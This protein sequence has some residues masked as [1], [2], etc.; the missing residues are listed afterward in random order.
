M[1][2]Q[3]FRPLALGASLIATIGFPS[4]GAAQDLADLQREL[5]EMRQHYDAELKRLQRDYDARIRRLEAQVKAARSKPPASAEPLQTGAPIGPVATAA[6]PPPPG[7]IAPPGPT[8][9]VSSPTFTI[10]T[11]PREPWPIGPATPPIA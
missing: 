7:V 11:P 1:E 9:A 3:F 8:A 10:G 2:C 5:K 4:P 6:P